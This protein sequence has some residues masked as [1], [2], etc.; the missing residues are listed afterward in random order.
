MNTRQ[1]P[2]SFEVVG[3]REIISLTEFHGIVAGHTGRDMAAV[4][5]RID[6]LHALGVPLPPE[7][8]MFYPVSKNLFDSAA[9]YAPTEGRT[10]GEVEPVYIRHNS[11][12]YFG[13]GSD[14]TDRDL[15]TKNVLASKESCPKPVSF[16]VIPIEDLDTLSLDECIARSRVDGRLIQEGFLNALLSPSDLINLLLV[17]TQIGDDDFVCFG[18]TIPLLSQDISEGSVWE[19]ELVFPDGSVLGHAYKMATGERGVLPS[20]PTLHHSSR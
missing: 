20:D 7:V 19:I 5:R 3:S 17:R 4:Q 12:F 1:T 15:E 13:I 8:P 6:D 11:K 10:S 9:E 18:G 14:H 16:Q 2:L